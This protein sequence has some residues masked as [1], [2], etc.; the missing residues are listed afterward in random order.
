MNCKS[1]QHPKLSNTLLKCRNLKYTDGIVNLSLIVLSLNNYMG[2]YS[3]EI[4]PAKKW[5]KFFLQ[6]QHPLSLHWLDLQIRFWS[7]TIFFIIRF[8]GIYAILKESHISSVVTK[9]QTHILLLSQRI[10]NLSSKIVSFMVL[11]LF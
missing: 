3:K 4:L 2:K 7:Y 9:T 8:R 10:T 11:M 6:V 1:C 5:C